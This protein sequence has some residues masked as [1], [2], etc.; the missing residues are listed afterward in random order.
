MFSGPDGDRALMFMLYDVNDELNIQETDQI[1][2]CA[3]TWK[4]LRTQAA[5]HKQTVT[6]PLL[7]NEG[8]QHEKATITIHVQKS[9]A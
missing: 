6:L 1:G 5:S 3:L 8:E 2:T 7:N 4:F 9:T